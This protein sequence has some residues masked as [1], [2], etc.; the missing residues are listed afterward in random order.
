MV[1]QPPG[2]GLRA[3]F[4]YDPRTFSIEFRFRHIIWKPRQ[5]PIGNIFDSVSEHFIF[6]ESITV[7][8]IAAILLIVSGIALL[9]I[10]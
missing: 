4:P 1:P 6:G 3:N 7:R 9:R 10:E 8:K 5:S 2:A